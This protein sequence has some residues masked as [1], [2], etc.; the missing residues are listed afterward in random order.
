MD[1]TQTLALSLGAAWASGI[2]LYATVFMMGL[3]GS[4]GTL[5][6]P[7]ELHVTTHPAVMSAAGFMF[8]LEFFADKIPGI[9]SVWDAIHT[10]IR[11]PAG[12]ILA[13][14]AVGQLDPSI[15]TAA[16]LIGGS[17]T[18]GSHFAK[19]GTRL[20]INTSPEPFTN[21]T[22]SLTEDALVIGGIWTAMHHPTIFLVA[23]GLFLLFLIWVLPVV[24]RGIRAMFRKLRGVFSPVAVK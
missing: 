23:L 6:L 13:A 17:V 3:L 5:T 22:A 10:F 12:A 14:A 20:L 4:H 11:I 2:N 1:L 9:D 18:A 16:L 7:P 15:Q 19:S 21:W 24:W 8:L